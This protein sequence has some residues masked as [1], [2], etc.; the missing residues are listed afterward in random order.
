MVKTNCSCKLSGSTIITDSKNDLELCK[1]ENRVCIRDAQEK[2]EQQKSKM[3]EK[4]FYLSIYFHLQASNKFT[5]Q[6]RQ[7]AELRGKKIQID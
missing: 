7:G 2:F 3:A 6:G 1:P 5:K 4:I